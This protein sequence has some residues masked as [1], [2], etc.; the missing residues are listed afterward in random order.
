MALQKILSQVEKT[1]QK[2]VEDIRKSTNSEVESRLSEARE[3][4][5]AISEEIANLKNNNKLCHICFEVS[6][7]NNAINNGKKKGFHVIQKPVPAIA[8]GNRTVCFLFH[9]DY[10]IVE[11]LQ[12]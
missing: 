1:G 10:H 11:L 2:Q 5:K 7:I 4:G 6:N 3:K 12:R 8:L 9:S